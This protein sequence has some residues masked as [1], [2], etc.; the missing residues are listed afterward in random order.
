M[1]RD[2]VTFRTSSVLRREAARLSFLARRP[3]WRRESLA[4]LLRTGDP[5][6][7]PL[8][9]ALHRSDWIAAHEL[10]LQH[11]V[12]RPRRFVLTPLDRG[13]RIE[14]IR[15]DFPGAAADAARRGEN[16]VAGRFDLLGYRSLSFSN[17][18]H[19][20]HVD[21]HFDPVHQRRGP[22][23]FWSRVP[24]L[25]PECGDHKIIWELNRHQYMLALGRAYWL[26]GDGRFRDAFVEHF[27]TW[28]ADN[29][30]LEGINW[31]SMLELGLRSISWIW[32][33]H[34][35]AVP[36]AGG[37]ERL[38]WSVDLLIALDRQL[39]L[40]AQNLSQFFSPNTH[41]LG[42]ALAL[43][44]AGRVLPEL[45]HAPHWEHVG[46]TVLLEQIGAQI[47]EDGGHAELST[48]YHRYTLD[49]YLL[50]LAVARETGDSAATPFS[51]ACMALARFARSM[52]DDNGIL[53]G[54]GDDDGGLLFPIAG[55]DP[56]DASDS[57]QLAAELLGAPELAVG[58]PAEEVIW[59]LG[60]GNSSREVTR[61]PSAA[62]ASTGYFVSRSDRGDHLTVD[63]G[64]HG[65][66]NG[67]HAHAD[68][69]SV[70]LRVR[71][72]RLLIDP[73]TGCYTINRA[74]RDR[75]RSSEAHNT[76]VVDRRPQSVPDGPFHW[77][78]VARGTAGDWQSGEGFDYFEGSHDGYAPMLHRRAILS[79]P[80]CWIFI[81]RLSAHGAHSADAHWHLDPAWSASLAG[82]GTVRANHQEGPTVWIASLADTCEIVWG[83]ANS[84]K[85]G[86]C[87]PVYG[88]VVPTST[89]RFSKAGDAP[90]DI[91]TVILDSPTA[92]ALERL[93]VT[94]DDGLI[95]D[96]TAFRVSTPE[97]T[98]T[99]LMTRWA[100]SV[101]PTSPR[102]I[103]SA[104]GLD[105]SAR[106]VC[107][108]EDQAG[109]RAEIVLDG[110]VLR[111]PST[112]DLTAN[113]LG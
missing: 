21:W 37:L 94:I 54:I 50:A 76:L 10:F 53:P 96:A 27:D 82:R 39:S 103:W 90:F 14:T 91:V 100:D 78:L 83:D 25:D 105:T 1:S 73:G 29:R 113:A 59:I 102:L 28:I 71:G 45:R 34:F 92:P 9:A 51:G 13:G 84:S 81:D 106:F 2:E 89:I 98:E 31:A 95:A 36:S 7:Q 20:S 66:L 72:H 57:L 16:L 19:G 86:W 6:L 74:L 22:K 75:F 49:F 41:L 101:P 77:Q 107:W 67:G 52:A 97:W 58:L 48:H 55:R 62:L 35:F 33:L 85:L 3:A 99:V 88:S 80:G 64:P 40:V 26:S 79:R 44:V 56:A 60:R 108:R 63:A 47:N 61:W 110:A 68:A 4:S 24:F 111:H 69:L 23:V 15:R 46:R 17:G 18:S 11:I 93:R 43:Y 104:G 109:S 87:A 30:P 112:V 5:S 32:A 8:R 42:E 38:P 65:F 70:T 12:T